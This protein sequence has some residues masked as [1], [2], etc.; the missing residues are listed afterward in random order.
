MYLT[1]R[2][3]L[4][5]VFAPLVPVLQVTI[6]N[7]VQRPPAGWRRLSDKFHVGFCGGPAGFTPVTGGA[8]A[9][10]IFP[11]MLTP[12]ITRHDVVKG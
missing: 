8:G 3:L 12:S 9:D 11:G 5:H 1:D 4:K 2:G 6:G 10:N 7:D